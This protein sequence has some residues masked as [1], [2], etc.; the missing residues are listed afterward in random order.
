MGH[1]RRLPI[2]L[3]LDCSE[4]M[5]GESIDAVRGG[6]RT[7]ISVL[8]GNPMAL[9]TA[10]LSVITFAS[11]ARQVV[12]LT[13][14]LK[15]NPPDFVMGSGTALGAALT[16]WQASMAREIV[17]STSTQK[18]DYKPICFLL[19]DGQPTDAWE[20]AADQVHG[21]VAAKRANVIAAACGP[22]A[23]IGKLRR[24]TDVVLQLKD[25]TPEVLGGFF[26]WIS[27]SV[28]SASQKVGG[29]EGVAVDL[30]G[31]PDVVRIAPASETSGSLDVD[32]Q[33]FLLARCVSKRSMYILRYGK[34]IVE[35][36]GFFGT[37]KPVY[38]G[39]ASHPVEAFEET[40]GVGGLKVAADLLQDPTPCP[41]CQ[42][43]LW[44]MCSCGRVHCCPH[45]KNTVTLTCPWCGTTDRYG[46]S[47]FDVGRGRG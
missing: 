16:L 38:K 45:Y 11:T 22:D 41:Y 23:D 35:S 7:L 12:P 13:D 6:L 34:S 20:S 44:A 1:D 42:N 18:G 14:L 27:A 47:S 46:A 40:E 17:R 2:Y 30:P 43:P 24:I 10:A 21:L 31:L 32:R 19:T 3:L 39:I 29:N 9:E 8:R 5:A 33:I 4:S 25:A 28:S 36:R 15:F 26:K 37:A